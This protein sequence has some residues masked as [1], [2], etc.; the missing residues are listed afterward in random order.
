MGWQ[1]DWL[2]QLVFAEVGR[3]WADI[4]DG[5]EFGPPPIALV[6]REMAEADW[7][8]PHCAGEVRRQWLYRGGEPEPVPPQGESGA[9]VGARRGMFYERGTVAFHVA[10]DRRRV[11]FTFTL[12]PR[13]GRGLIL[14]VEGQGAGGR[15]C[16]GPGP[17]WKS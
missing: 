5:S 16:P 14:G 17:Q 15:L 2:Y 9:D 4:A 12:G 3:V 11:L 7:D 13:F 6:V 1:S 8:G 10:P